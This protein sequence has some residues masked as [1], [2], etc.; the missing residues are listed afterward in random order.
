MML[1]KRRDYNLATHIE[2]D[3]WR[4]SPGYEVCIKN[5]WTRD[6]NCKK[7]KSVPSFYKWL[8]LLRILLV[9]S[10]SGCEPS[11]ELHVRFLSSSTILDFRLKL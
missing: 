11:P 1:V 10:L 9:I 3:L 6:Y 4:L 7:F 8:L 2:K 5:I